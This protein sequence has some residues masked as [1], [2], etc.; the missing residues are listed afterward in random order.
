[1][2]GVWHCRALLQ[3]V[4]ADGTELRSREAGELLA[5]YERQT[6]KDD[7]ADVILQALARHNQTSLVPQ[8]EKVGLSRTKINEPELLTVSVWADE[9]E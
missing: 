5:F 7:F 1:M 9:C 6:K 3:Q 4:M 2:T 8:N